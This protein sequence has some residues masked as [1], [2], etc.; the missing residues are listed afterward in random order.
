MFGNSLAGRFLLLTLAFL[1]LAELLILIPATASFRRDYLELRIE[2]ARVVGLTVLHTNAS[3]DEDSAQRILENAD[4]LNIRMRLDTRSV[5][6]LQRPLPGEKMGFHEVVLDEQDRWM[7]LRDAVRRYFLPGEELVRV[8][9]SLSANS[10]NRIDIV[11]RSGDLRGAMRQYSLEILGIS[12]I[13]SLIVAALML[14]VVRLFVVAPIYRFIGS[15]KAF[16]SDPGDAR[17]IIAPSARVRELRDAELALQSMQVELGSSFRQKERLSQLG[18]AIAKINHEMRNV[19]TPAQ[20]VADMIGDSSDP[21][22]KRAAPKILKSISR[23][24]DL[25]RSVL[26]FARLREPVTEPTRFSLADLVSEVVELESVHVRDGSV[27]FEVLV[28][29]GVFVEADRNQMFHAFL[30]LVRNARQAAEGGETPG[31]VTIEAGESGDGV[32]ALVRDN[33]PGLPATS[34]DFLFKPFQGGP[35][36]GSSGLGLAIARDCV[37]AN[38]GELRLAE[39]SDSGAAFEIFLPRPSGKL[40]SPS[41]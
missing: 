29:A 26:D 32:R 34:L 27:G 35:G 5:L 39:N 1:A 25:T 19:L 23:A 12:S 41:G 31:L 36:R 38:S 16:G 6:V 40:D 13:V 11:I 17:R 4:A 30:N 9:S 22:V 21:G 33:G 24:V 14:L 2:K 8:E 18:E 10:K 15:I 3:V 37:R 28:P 7:Q 20:L